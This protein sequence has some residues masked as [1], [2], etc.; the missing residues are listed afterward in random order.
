MQANA[1]DIIMW[2]LAVW[3]AAHVA[4]YVWTVG[5][6]TGMWAKCG[7]AGRWAWRVAPVVACW[8]YR[9]ARAAAIRS[10]ILGGNRHTDRTVILDAWRGDEI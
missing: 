3:L 8:A 2:S 4:L 10:G 6:Q 1:L 9:T 7:R 5:H